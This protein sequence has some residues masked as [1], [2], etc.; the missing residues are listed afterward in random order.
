MNTLLSL[1][2]YEAPLPDDLEDVTE[3]QFVESGEILREAGE[4]DPVHA[5]LVVAVT[6]GNLSPEQMADEF[7]RCI[8][9]MNTK[10]ER[11]SGTIPGS[12]EVAV[13]FTEHGM[14]WRERSIFFPLGDRTKLHVSASGPASHPELDSWLEQ[15]ARYAR[16][17]TRVEGV[18]FR[19]AHGS[20]SGFRVVA[21]VELPIPAQLQG[22]TT[23]Q[24]VSVDGAVRLCVSLDRSVRL[25]AADGSSA[26][27]T[28]VIDGYCQPGAERRLEDAKDRVSAAF[29]LPR[30]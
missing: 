26:E 13:A 3:Y 17:A 4:A 18:R 30:R 5:K 12:V 11:R 29:S 23:I 7:V 28:L 10:V 16:P 24:L 2:E 22:P 9:A 8:V 20:D 21:N 25:R 15:A 19:A 27:A 14:D 6:Q 1:D